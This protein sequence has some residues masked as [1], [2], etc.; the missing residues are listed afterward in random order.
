MRIFLGVLLGM[1]CLIGCKEN[2]SKTGQKDQTISL[3]TVEIVTTPTLNLEEANR[4]A[5]LPLHCA[6]VEYPNKLNNVLGAHLIWNR[7]KHYTLLFMAVL[8]GI[9]LYMAIGLWYFY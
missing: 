9:V 1:T 7:L 4:L 2:T 8:I 6:V 5:E 3:E